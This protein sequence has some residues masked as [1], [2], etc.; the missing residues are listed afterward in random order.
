MQSADFLWIYYTELFPFVL[1]QAVKILP[2]NEL[3]PN[4]DARAVAKKKKI[5]AHKIC[6][7]IWSLE[8]FAHKHFS[9]L[10]NFMMVS[11]FAAFEPDFLFHTSTLFSQQ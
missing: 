2:T 10:F 8:V 1:S 7:V 4:K 11:D 9:T 5:K 6:G 3:R